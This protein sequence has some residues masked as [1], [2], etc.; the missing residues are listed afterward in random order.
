MPIDYGTSVEPEVWSGEVVE[1]EVIP[2]EVAQDEDTLPDEMKNKLTLPNIPMEYGKWKDI[3]AAY[4][5]EIAQLSGRGVKT[6][7]GR[8][9]MIAYHLELADD[10]LTRAKVSLDTI[11]G[12]KRTRTMSA[13][14]QVK[15]FT[16]FFS[17]L[18]P[19][20]LAAQVKLFQVPPIDT[21]RSVSAVIHDLVI[22]AMAD[23]AE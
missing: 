1:G 11:N 5:E 4:S 7:Q 16:N 12:E 9:A 15:V 10:H 21:H 20:Q 2:N 13:A 6:F 14:S 19:V 8:V 3:W 23:E 22:A 18:T 17:K